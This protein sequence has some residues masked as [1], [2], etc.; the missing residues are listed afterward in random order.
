[1][2][3]FIG[4]SPEN[5]A[6]RSYHDFL[7]KIILNFGL[8][9]ICEIGC[10]ANPEFSYP[11]LERAKDEYHL[12]DIS[13]TELAKAPDEYIKIVADVTS[14]DLPS[15]H[16]Y[17][18]IFTKMLAEHV[19]DGK[20]FHTNI[21]HLLSPNGI[22]VHFFPTLFNVPFIINKI[23]PE[24][25]SDK[26]L[27]YFS[28]YHHKFPAKY[29]W[30]Y[31][32]TK[33]QIGRFDDLGYRVIVYGG[34]FGHEG[35]WEKIPVFRNIHVAKTSFLLKHPNPHFTSYAIIVVAKKESAETIDS[36]II[37]EY[38]KHFINSL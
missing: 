38:K 29:S 25:I 3:L 18:L 33:K 10:G 17:D 19:A 26:L 12:M 20:A 14:P 24:R 32:A 5:R 15:E 27:Y 35:Y 34:F 11:E 4:Y 30:C 37:D 1:M 13:K 7:K 21:L 36:G 23:S 8:R 16:K 31:G 22:A 2:V 9:T 6:W 28:R